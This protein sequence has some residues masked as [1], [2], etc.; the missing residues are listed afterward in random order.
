MVRGKSSLFSSLQTS[1]RMSVLRG[2]C[3]ISE[4]VLEDRRARRVRKGRGLGGGGKAEGGGALG[5]G[6]RGRGNGLRG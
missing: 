1:V 2:D 3:S 4:T 6:G 5:S